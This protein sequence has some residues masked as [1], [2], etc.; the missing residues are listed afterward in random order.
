M[1]GAD[2]K[3]LYVRKTRVAGIVVF[4]LAL[5]GILLFSFVSFFNLSFY[6][7][8]ST[9]DD[10]KKARTRSNPPILLCPFLF[11]RHMEQEVAHLL[12]SSPSFIFSFK[13]SWYVY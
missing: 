12:I 4:F 2:G 13:F 10:T 3:E 7:A 6:A 8:H 11:P 9:H 1:D 5:E